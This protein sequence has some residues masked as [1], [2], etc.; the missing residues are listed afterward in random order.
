[1]RRRDLLAGAIAGAIVPSL[2]RAAADAQQALP[3]NVD[4]AI[5]GGGIAGLYSAWRLLTGARDGTPPK[6]AV[7]EASNR[8][9]GR[10]FSA[11]PDGM[12]HVP[13]ELGAMRIVTS[14]AF[15]LS[16]TREMG[17]PLAEFPMGTSDNLVY[18]RT[19]RFRLRDYAQ[20]ATIPYALAPSERGKSPDELLFSAIARL[21]PKYAQLDTAG[22]LAAK[23]AT[24]WQGKPL[25]DRGFWNV[26]SEILSNEAIDLIREGGGYPSFIGNWNAAE[27]AAYL[28]SDFP[29]GA[30]YKT[31]RGGMQRLPLAVK[32]RVERAG[33]FVRAQ[34]RLVSLSTIAGD[35]GG[36]RLVF[37]PARAGEAVRIVN[38]KSVI[39]ALPKRAIELIDTGTLLA[40]P[41]VRRAFDAVDRVPATKVFF[42]YRTPWW[43]QLGL[44]SGRSNTDLPMAQCYY[45]GTESE[46]AG[47][48]RYSTNS[49][50]M[51]SYAN[52]GP[53]EFWRF[54]AGLAGAPLTAPVG[55]DLTKQ[56][57]A[58]HGL[59]LPQPYTSLAV[60]WGRDPYGAA[61]H[62]WRP[63]ER[64]WE[65]MPRIRRPIAG[66]PLSIVGEAWSTE[67]GW[68]EGALN[69]AE[70]VLQEQYGLARPAWLPASHTIGS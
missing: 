46:Q 23:R 67:A 10:I 20:T 64:S 5:V 45:F 65:V 54:A 15:V 37:A 59:T 29:A 31:I 32:A 3:E 35:S 50:L 14:Q 34:A 39:L 49:L 66:L 43:R 56:L 1:M 42:G 38:A 52:D 40:A 62:I 60:D 44:R 58:V 24:K 53:S 61:W 19:K 7:F 63:G 48:E 68:I 17:L 70:H 69:T 22:W 47:G 16:L 12:P 8:F 33:G 11:L 4:V 57:D 21:V 25:W 36:F 55:D 27:A 26:L 28:T 2:V 41:D 18:L 6:V 30:A 51:A 13:A 9:G